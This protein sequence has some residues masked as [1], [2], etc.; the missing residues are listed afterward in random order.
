MS[1]SALVLVALLALAP[2]SATAQ[3]Q[4]APERP[5]GIDEQLGRSVP[6][7]LVLR[8]E[9]GAPVALG[10]LLGKPTILTLN[11]FRCAALC[12]PQLNGMVDV[13]NRTHAVPGRDFQVLTVSFDDRDT[14]AVAAQKRANYLGQLKRPFPPGAWRFLTGEAP[15]TRALADAVGFRFQ[16]RGADFN[17]P[18]ALIFLSPEGKVT[19][20]L[21]GVAYLPA[22]L[23]RAALEAAQG[24]A[25]ATVPQWLSVCYAYDPGSRRQVFSLARTA[26]LAGLAAVVGFVAVWAIRARRDGGGRADT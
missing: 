16:R 14:A 9:A 7:D 18:A 13:L 2:G 24:K 20:Y 6:L 8:D 3:A 23:H 1:G 4:P 12:T 15:A 11:Y 25:Q 22:D 5:V 17:H 26:L 10:T 19:R 21:H